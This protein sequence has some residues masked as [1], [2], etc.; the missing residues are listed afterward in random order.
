[1]FGKLT[2]IT[3]SLSSRKLSEY[4]ILTF[5]TLISPRS[6]LQ[7]NDMNMY[8]RKRLAI[9]GKGYNDSPKFRKMKH[10]KKTTTFAH[11]GITC[12]TFVL[13]LKW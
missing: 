3:L 8:K 11:L 13:N 12:N 2:N 10:T 7:N 9:Y 5:L 6:K 4:K 1:M